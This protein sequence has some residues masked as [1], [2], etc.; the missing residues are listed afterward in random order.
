VQLIQESLDAALIVVV[1]NGK[2]CARTLD[3]IRQNFY[4]KAP[5]SID[6]RIE[7]RASPHRLAS[8]KAPLFISQIARP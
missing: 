1:P 6:L 5:R 8:G 3:V 2:F 4:A 7:V